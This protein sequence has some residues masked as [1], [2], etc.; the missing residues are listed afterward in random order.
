MATKTKAGASKRAIA[1]AAKTDARAGRGA[2]APA[3]APGVSPSTAARSMRQSTEGVPSSHS[4]AKSTS[5]A[6]DST[7]GAASGPKGGIKVRAI[8][9]LY[10]GDKRRR[11]G[12]VFFINKE[13]E[14]SEKSMERVSRNTPERLT[15]GREELKR[16]HD[17]IVSGR[18]GTGDADVLK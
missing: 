12:D 18:L 10:Y 11:V 2:A 9:K 1:A 14:F 13:S 15:S 4:T 16:E 6:E 7:G 17:D 5:A 8:Q 3:P